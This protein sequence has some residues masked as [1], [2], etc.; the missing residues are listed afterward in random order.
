[1]LLASFLLCLSCVPSL[2]TRGSNEGSQVLE[3][4]EVIAPQVVAQTV[5]SESLEGITD[6]VEIGR[7]SSRLECRGV[8]LLSDGGRVAIQY[9]LEAVQ[10]VVTQRA[11]ELAGG[12]NME[13]RSCIWI[14]LEVMK[15]SAANAGSSE[16]QISYIGNREEVIRRPTRVDCKGRALWG[17]GVWTPVAFHVSHPPDG[18]ISYGYEVT[19]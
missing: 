11:Y 3:S 2:L 14:S 4:C 12:I 18:E 16:E 7:T 6:P 19:H 8:A 9:H 15:L 17:T 13:G 1:M 10:D 5:A